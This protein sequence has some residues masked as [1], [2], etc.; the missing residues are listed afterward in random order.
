LTKYHTMHPGAGGPAIII[1]NAGTDATTGFAKAKHSPKAMGTRDGLLIGPLKRNLKSELAKVLNCDDM[2]ARAK[3]LLSPGALAYYDAGAE[4]LTSR[5][6]ALEC[7]DRDWRLRPR[8]FIDVSNVDTG[9]TLLGH[10]LEA[11]I[12]AA[13]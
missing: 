8:N 10:R 3:Q 6:E 12:M 1:K 9:C 13:P 2:Q 7:W 11:P 4:D 5:K